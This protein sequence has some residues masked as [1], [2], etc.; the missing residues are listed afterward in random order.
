MPVSYAIIYKIRNPDRVKYNF[1]LNQ[2]NMY[3]RLN[4]SQGNATLNRKR[5]LLIVTSAHFLFLL[6]IFLAFFI[7]NI[8]YKTMPQAI[9]VTLVSS[10]DLAND[11]NTKV[12]SASAPPVPQKAETTPRQEQPK[13]KETV[14]KKT[15]KTTPAPVADKKW[16]QLDASEIIKSTQTVVK[17]PQT[18]QPV[19]STALNPSDIAG[20]IRQSIKGIQFKSNLP[21]GSSSTG[22]MALTYYDQVSTALYQLWNQPSKLAMGGKN[23]TVTIK[24]QID[25]VGRVTLARIIQQSGIPEMDK[26]VQDLISRLSTLPKPPDG[27]IEL[28]ASLIL[29]E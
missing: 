24:L 28:E 29:T 26:S 16:K 3:L 15:E 2:R 5:L 18:V 9:G 4:I 19:D 21:A 25:S 17:K 12:E 23:P 14:Q 7:D 10:S 27:N 8:F 6:I 22:V 11:N 13:I 20:K 1:N